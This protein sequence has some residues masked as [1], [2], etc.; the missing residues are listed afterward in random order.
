MVSDT[1]TY[2]TISP[3]PLVTPCHFLRGIGHGPDQS[4]FL[5]PPKLILEGVLY[6]TSPPP[7]NRAIRFALP[8]PICRFPNNR[9]PPILVLFDFLAFF[10]FPIFLAFLCVFALFFFSRN[11][12]LKVRQ[13][14]EILASFGGSLPF[15]SAK[16]QGLECQGN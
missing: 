16:K 7:Q 9:D 15:S 13:K 6:G 3:P 4:H 8:P 1:P 11:F 5:S 2:D 12:K 14:R 10:G